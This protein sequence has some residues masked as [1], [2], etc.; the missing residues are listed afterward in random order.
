MTQIGQQARR[1]RTQRGES[2]EAVARHAG[3]STSTY[4]RIENGHNHPSYET[5]VRVAD[6]LEVPVGELMAPVPAA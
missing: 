6:A 1:I 3:V 2:Q 4:A 5:L